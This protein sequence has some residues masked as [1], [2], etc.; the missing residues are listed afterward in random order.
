MPESPASR[1]VTFFCAVLN[2]E[3][4]T[5]EYSNAGH[6]PPLLM[7]GNGEVLRLEPGGPPL[8][9]SANSSY[10]QTSA[11]LSDDDALVMY[12]DGVL[13]A[14]GPDG[15]D[16]GEAGLLSVLQSERD[17]T[18]EGLNAALPSAVERHCGGVFGDDLTL[19]TLTVRRA[20]VEPTT[21]ETPPDVLAKSAES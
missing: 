10:E 20:S 4:R 5:L 8:G 13:D 1:F 7:R 6:Y 14:T 16:F 15:S 21:G 19:L 12:T 11:A 18:A 9:L 17:E 3:D 2:T